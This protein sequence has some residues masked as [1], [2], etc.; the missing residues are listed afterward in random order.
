MSFQ[1][2][3]SVFQ[4]LLIGFCA[5][6]MSNRTLFLL[7]NEVDFYPF[8]WF[9]GLAT[10]FA[11][12]FSSPSFW[13]K[14]LA[15]L[16]GLAAAVLFFWKNWPIDGNLV[17][18]LAVGFSYFFP[19]NRSSIRRNTLSK[20]LAIALSWAI[21]TVWLP[22]ELHGGDWPKFLFFER[23]FFIAVLAVGYDLID[24]E[25]DLASGLATIPARF[26]VKFSGRLIFWLLFAAAACSWNLW[27]TGFY[28]KDNLAGMAVS[29]LA[30]GFLLRQLGEKPGLR[31]GKIWVD[32]MMVGQF[33]MTILS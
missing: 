8:C 3:K 6:T 21:L 29:L 17:V 22:A 1:K 32:L 20:P 24:F 19:K 14:R 27:Q 5:V 30:T 31:G 15:W 16:A 26:G 33:L 13:K 7:K 9:S 4:F 11:Y 10:L 18:L 2:L 28:S 23:L 25:R 12:H